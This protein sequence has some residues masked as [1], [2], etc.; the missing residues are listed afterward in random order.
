MACGHACHACGF[1]LLISRFFDF[2]RRAI[3]SGLLIPILLVVAFGWYAWP[4]PKTAP[5]S[6][7]EKRDS[8]NLGARK[9][10]HDYFAEEGGNCWREM[11]PQEIAMKNEKIK[12]EA[13]MC[14]DF[15]SKAQHLGFYIP[16]TDYPAQ[17]SSRLIN[18]YQGT[19]DTFVQRFQDK[20]EVGPSEGRKT[21]VKDLRFTKYLVIFHE[22]SIPQ[23]QL[24]ALELQ[25]KQRGL[26]VDFHSQE[27]VMAR[28]H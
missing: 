27:Y 5:A 11:I 25:A 23:S 14:M 15:D 10:L 3:I 16:D 1:W 9:T 22:V 13:Q 17:V 2:R 28:M 8:E 18:G 12:V 21:Q 19:I 26:I 24:D 4:E 6:G 20:I 7:Q